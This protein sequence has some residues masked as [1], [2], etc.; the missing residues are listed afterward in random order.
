MHVSKLPVL[1][2]KREE[3]LAVSHSSLRLNEPEYPNGIERVGERQDC[4][5]DNSCDI[6]SYLGTFAC[7]LKDSSHC[8]EGHMS[9]CVHTHAIIK[10]SVTSGRPGSGQSPDHLM[11][12]H[13]VLGGFTFPYK[14]KINSYNVILARFSLQL[15]DENIV[16]CRNVAKLIYFKKIYF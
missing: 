1:V 12:S 9:Y 5:R 3:M 8:Y 10:R 13:L 11:T 4:D 16:P 15:E 2:E 7:I 14:R 6:W